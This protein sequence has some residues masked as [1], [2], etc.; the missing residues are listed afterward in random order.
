MK[1]AFDIPEDIAQRL[2]DSWGDVPRHALEALAI[3]AY[4]SETLT[5]AEVGSL[6][7]LQERWA[8]ERL[9]SR[10]GA[11]LHY[12]D[13]EFEEDMRRLRAIQSP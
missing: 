12:S 1:V 9:L 13:A 6:L 8:V 10:S 5:S 7:G 11:S 4:R 3:A 2:R